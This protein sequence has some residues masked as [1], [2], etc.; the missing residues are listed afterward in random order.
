M[1]ERD[2]L[3]FAMGFYKYDQSVGLSFRHN[4]FTKLTMA[5]AFDCHDVTNNCKRI[6]EQFKCCNLAFAC[7]A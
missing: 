1:L 2:G 4:C 6:F 7:C 3:K 5:A